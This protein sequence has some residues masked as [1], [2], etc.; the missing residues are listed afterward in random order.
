MSSQF[1]DAARPFQGFLNVKRLDFH[2]QFEAGQDFTI[3]TPV[4]RLG[5]LFQV[6]M[7]FRG[8]IS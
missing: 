3:Q 8:N 7:E 1:P 5:L 4:I 2:R 6:S